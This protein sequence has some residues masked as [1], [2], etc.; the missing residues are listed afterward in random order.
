MRWYGL[1]WS[2]SGYGPLDI[3]TAKGNCFLS[4]LKRLLGLS[5]LWVSCSEIKGYM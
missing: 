4:F 5:K 3:L 1:N 2:G